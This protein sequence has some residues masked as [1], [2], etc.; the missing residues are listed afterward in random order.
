MLYLLGVNIDTAFFC[1]AIE[2]FAK[3][4]STHLSEEHQMV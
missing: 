3:T 1:E 2:G 4:F